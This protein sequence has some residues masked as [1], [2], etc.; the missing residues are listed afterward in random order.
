MTAT[1]CVAPKASSSAW[2]LLPHV[3]GGTAEGA[4]DV[5]HHSFHDLRHWHGFTVSKIADVK[6]G[7]KWSLSDI[8]GAPCPFWEGSRLPCKELACQGLCHPTCLWC[9]CTSRKRSKTISLTLQQLFGT[10]EF[11]HVL[12]VTGWTAHAAVLTQWSISFGA[13]FEWSIM[14][15]ATHATDFPCAKSPEVL[16]TTLDIVVWLLSQKLHIGLPES[17]SKGRVPRGPESKLWSYNATRP[18]ALLDGWLQE[19]KR[20]S[21]NLRR[22]HTTWATE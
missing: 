17:T 4:E 21:L 18:P 8:S 1:T 14:K 16:V 7:M 19:M 10:K 5:H 9:F 12:L 22:T 20:A 15:N 11:C 6:C 3:Q 2:N 13:S